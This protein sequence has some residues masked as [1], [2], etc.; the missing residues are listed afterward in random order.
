MLQR[1][2]DALKG[3]DGSK[4]RKWITYLFV[5]V[6]SF[7][8]A[9]WGAYGI[10][11]L[12]F[13][14][15]NYAAEA[16]GSKI[17]LEDA[18]NAWLRQQSAWQQRLGGSEL[19]PPLRTR[20]QDQ[21]LESLIRRAILT[22]RSHDLGY[23]VSHE[24]LRDA[25][26][27]EPA[28]QVDGKYDPQA[29]KAAL[30]QAGI[31]LDAYE[32]QLRTDLQ[33]LQLEGGIRVSDF[34]TPAELT[35]LADLED[36]QREVRYLVLP[37]D[38]FHSSAAVDDAAVQAYY[39]AHL[40]DYMSPESVRLQ[41]AELRLEALAAQ[42]ELSDADL[43]AAY[44]KD[45]S[46]L[47]V[48]EKRHARHILIT[49]KDDATAL[50]LAQQVL[51]QVKSGKDFGELAKQYSQDPGS[52]QNGGD[53][54]WAER[55]TFVK[56]FADALYAMKVGEI[57]GPVKTQYGYHIIRLDE[58]Q[59]G[60]AKSFEEARPELEAQVRRTRATDRFGEIQEQLQAKLAEPGADLGALAQQYKLQPGEVK[61]F[62]KGAGGV[63][64]GAAPQLQE[65]LF[66]EPPLANGKVGG[67]ALLGDDRLV[68]FKVLEHRAAAPKP[69]A[70][71]RE[72]IVNAITKEQGTQAAL[73]AAQRAR[74]ELLK[75]AS[76]DSIAQQL[77]VS[78]DPAHFIG[79]N[80]PS[81]PAPIRAA[82]FAS[83]RPA[84][85][86]EFQALTLS[87]GGA[88]LV[89]V[90]AVRTAPAQD[91]EAQTNRALQE[92]ERLGTAV[93]LAYVDEVRR[94]ASVRK[95]PKAFE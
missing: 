72:S 93:A 87:D 41:Y 26:Q 69:L 79:R 66:G 71:V 56:P 33:Q 59:P 47:E 22:E 42:Q 36:Q 44:E 84:G 55:S 45:K 17:S 83:A 11:N 81:V 67:P 37:A 92:S 25:V 8:F 23:R 38:R 53:L 54:G 51:A 16:N 78:A 90:S 10:V 1:I 4:H 52:A 31:S 30:A 76:F 89:A 64:F 29:A 80:D 65:L 73:A 48:P 21:V 82:A 3:R 35:R 32:Q 61:E 85:K 74:D 6:L 57:A 70:E 63:P 86:P 60:K 24:A 50:A 91:K 88:A 7:V 95:N 62:V 46:R 34:L 39:K 28:F 12:N 43:R 5:G 2:G 68:I 77:K 94:T 18:R 19:P 20:L 15:S 9:A 75:G 14:G 49:G 58:I 13:G 40:A 27:N